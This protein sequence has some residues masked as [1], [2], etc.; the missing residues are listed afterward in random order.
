MVQN[1]IYSIS[2]EGLPGPPTQPSL[3]QVRSI[4]TEAKM[5]FTFS[6]IQHFSDSQQKTWS[7]GTFKRLHNAWSR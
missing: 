1:L 4:P 3:Q 7:A 6:I 2:E 5:Q